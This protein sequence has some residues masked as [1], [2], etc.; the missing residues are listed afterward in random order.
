MKSGETGKEKRG[1]AP[2]PAEGAEVRLD[3]GFELSDDAPEAFAVAGGVKKASGCEHN[4]R[5]VGREKGMIWGYNDIYKCTKCKI[6][7]KVWV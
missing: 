4:W 2:E 7:K 6:T 1:T 5:Y 3:E